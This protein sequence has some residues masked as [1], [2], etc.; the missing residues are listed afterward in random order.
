[1]I[2][3]ELNLDEDI[4]RPVI[5]SD[6]LLIALVDTGASVPVWT[7]DVNILIDRLH[8][9]LINDR[10][11]LSGFGGSELSVAYKIPSLTLSDIT[12][13]N[14]PIVV[15]TKLGN[16]PFN[17]ILCASMFS[18]MIYQFDTINNKMRIYIPDNRTDRTFKV[19][20]SNGKYHIFITFDADKYRDKE[21]I[22][23]MIE[24]VNIDETRT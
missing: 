12:F 24:V 18:G 7:G 20:N 11:E 15:S 19:K 2:T 23:S 21:I 1:M 13:R 3:C 10:A 4:D 17:I 14:V 5:V 6:N 8:A 9:V 16:V 22:E